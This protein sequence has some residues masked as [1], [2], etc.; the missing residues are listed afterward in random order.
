MLLPRS[1]RNY[2]KE[3]TGVPSS[4]SSRRSA[5]RSRALRARGFAFTSSSCDLVAPWTETPRGPIEA[6]EDEVEANPRARS[7]RLRVA[8]RRDDEKLGTPVPSFS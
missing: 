7:A 2:E 5:T 4:S 3:G 1:E 8:E 6:Q